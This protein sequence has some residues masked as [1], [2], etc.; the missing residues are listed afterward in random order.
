M[1]LPIMQ[2]WKRLDRVPSILAQSIETW[3]HHHPDAEHRLVDDEYV[4]TWLTKNERRFPSVIH[5]G[6]PPIR[7]I[8]M[9]RYCHLFEYGGLFTD[10]DFYCLRPIY[11]LLQSAD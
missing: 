2:T 7:T 1:R 4:W 11:P 3:P 5:H 6:K 10:I 9:F 8:D